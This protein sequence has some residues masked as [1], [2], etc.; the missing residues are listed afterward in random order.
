MIENRVL[1]ISSQK[2]F[3]SSFFSLIVFLRVDVEATEKKNA[4]AFSLI[5]GVVEGTNNTITISISL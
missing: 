2:P 3:S 4:Y 1:K 5:F